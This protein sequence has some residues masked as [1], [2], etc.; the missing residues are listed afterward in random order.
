MTGSLAPFRRAWSRLRGDER[1][2]GLIEMALFAPFVAL[3]TVGVVDL[4]EGVTRR[5]E[6]HQAV[7]RTME[8]VAARRFEIKIVNGEPDTT[9]IRADAAEAAGVPIEEVSAVAWLECDGVQQPSFTADCPPLASPDPTCAYPVP[10]PGAKCQPILARYVEVRIDTHYRPTFG[11]VV[12]GDAN[13]QVPLFA[14]AAV[15][16]Q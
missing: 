7:H 1:G 6:L 4:T 3:L 8:K 10:P 13:G 9:Y 16:V 15:R 5:A 14:E 12:Q 2:A 11:K